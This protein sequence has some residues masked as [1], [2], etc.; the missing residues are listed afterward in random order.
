MSKKYFSA[1]ISKQN[2]LFGFVFYIQYILG[3]KIAVILSPHCVHAG[4]L[5]FA[6]L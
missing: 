5:F 4:K 6:Q 3:G 2:V 1:K